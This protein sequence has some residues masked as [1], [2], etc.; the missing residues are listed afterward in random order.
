GHVLVVLGVALD[1]LGQLDGLQPGPERAREEAL[2]GT[3]EPLLEVLEHAHPESRVAS[4][5]GTTRGGSGRGRLAG[6]LLHPHRTGRN[7][8][9]RPPGPVPSER[10]T[11][12]RGTTRR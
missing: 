10:R 8:A 4:S 11:G 3:F 2:D 1:G 9:E 6:G 7:V 12:A 5:L